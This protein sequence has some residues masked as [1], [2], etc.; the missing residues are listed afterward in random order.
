MQNLLAKNRTVYL[1]CPKPLHKQSLQT[2]AF[3]ASFPIVYFNILSLKTM[4]FRLFHLKS[5]NQFPPRLGSV[6]MTFEAN[7]GNFDY[8]M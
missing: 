6:I 8:Q 3:S 1:E 4:Y 7:W 5:T 2:A